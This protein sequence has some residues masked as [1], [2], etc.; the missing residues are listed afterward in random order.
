MPIVLICFPSS[1]RICRRWLYVSLTTMLPWRVTATPLAP[2]HDPKILNCPF[3]LPFLPNVRMKCPLLLNTCRTCR[4]QLVY[5]TYYT[6]YTKYMYSINMINENYDN[7][8]LSY[9]ILNMLNV[10]ITFYINITPL[11][12][13]NI[14]TIYIY[15]IR[16]SY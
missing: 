3:P 12:C 13:Y 1:V 6:K 10:H 8:H 2:L 9:E 4:M 16:D 15:I 11:Q 14:N 5:I 7:Y